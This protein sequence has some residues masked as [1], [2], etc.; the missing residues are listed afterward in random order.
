MTGTQP[1]ALLTERSVGSITGEFFV[2]SYQRGYRWGADEVTR[3]LDDLNQFTGDKYYLQPL[4]VKRRVGSDSWELVD[5]QQRLTTLYLIQKYI[6]QEL[7]RTATEY[8]LT[9]ETRLGSSEYLDNLDQHRSTGNIDF[10]HMFKAHEAITEWFEQQ[11]NPTVAAMEIY[12]KLVKDVRV[13]WYE[14]D[15]SVDTHTLFRRLNV[16]RIPLTD[17]ELVK[18]LVLSQV[19]LHHENRL[20]EVAAQWDSIE[21]ELRD[22]SV[23]SFISGSSASQGTHMGLILD[24]LAGT[25][26]DRTTPEHQTFEVLRPR[27]ERN[28]LE[29]WNEVV[30]TQSQIMGWYR[31]RELF[32][33]I[34]VLVQMNTPLHELLD[35][36]RGRT[37]TAFC[38]EL[39]RRIANRLNLTRD[40]LAE[41]TYGDPTVRLVLLLMNIETILRSTGS[42]ERFSFQELSGQ[43]WSIEHIHAQSAEPLVTAEQWSEWVRLQLQGLRALRLDSEAAK[44]EADMPGEG[45]VM[46]RSSFRALEER[47]VKAYGAADQE[48]MSQ[49]ID[50]IHNLALLDSASNSALS[51]STFAVKRSKLID[52]DRQG[53]F[54]PICTRNV[55]LKYYSRSTDSGLSLWG[56]DDRAAYLEAMKNSLE[57]YLTKVA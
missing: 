49:D 54:I 10:W 45:E 57:P 35:A 36:A 28:P 20:H 33:R 56:A 38:R 30:Q 8:S 18:A 1:S 41:L 9:Y 51:N 31:D 40:G 24:S 53:A 42:S 44:I 7:P 39:I 52:R 25:R 4:V 17:A 15:S 6:Q 29:F 55:F 11:K 47:I 37:R 27:I 23:W 13:I 32:H 3:L 50:G 19:R 16:G 5:G 26:R 22:P 21:R 2:P 12:G 14:V 43:G 34:G 46:T 48:M